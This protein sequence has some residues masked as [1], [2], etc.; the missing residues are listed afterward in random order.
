MI[1]RKLRT[2]ACAC[3]FPQFCSGKSP[4]SGTTKVD[5]M[6]EANVQKDYVYDVYDKIAEHFH[7][8]RY[9]MWPKVRLFLEG[10]DPGSL[11]CDVGC[12]NGKYLPAGNGRIFVQGSDMCANLVK[13]AC[14]KGGSALVADNQQLPFRSRAFDAAISI[15]VIHHF[16]SWYCAPDSKLGNREGRRSRRSL[17]WFGKAVGC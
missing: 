2:L 12:G 17:A 13:I 3:K 9:N 11:V 10:L 8:T 6:K 5:L 7:H 16:A 4:E 1:L 15:A 14:E